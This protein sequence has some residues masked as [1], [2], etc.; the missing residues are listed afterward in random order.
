M[1]RRILGRGRGGSWPQPGDPLRGRPAER[2]LQAADA[3]VADAAALERAALGSRVDTD[4][5]TVEEVAEE[6]AE[7][8][9][10]RAPWPPLT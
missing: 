6:V 5:R 2:L 7:A 3:A 1:T 9:A 4:G 10:I 8:V